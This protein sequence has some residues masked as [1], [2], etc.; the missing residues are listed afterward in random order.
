MTIYMVRRA[1]G[2]NGIG[3]NMVLFDNF[4]DAIIR[5]DK[6]NTSVSWN[7]YLIEKYE[8]GVLGGIKVPKAE[9]TATQRRLGLKER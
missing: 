2:R 8:L 7:W 4:D 9:R 5:F 6:M 3:T 1:S